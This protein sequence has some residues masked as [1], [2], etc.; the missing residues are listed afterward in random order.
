M[1]I[2][3]FCFLLCVTFIVT[4]CF[5]SAGT[6][7]SL[8]NYQYAIKKEDLQRAIMKVIKNNPN[9]YRDTSLDNSSAHASIDS[10]GAHYYN[11]IKNYVTI[12]IT[13]GQI[14]NEYTFR[15]Y[16]DDEYWKTSGSSEIFICY[17]FDKNHKGGSEGNGGVTKEMLKGFTDV[18]EKEFI[19]KIDRELNLTHTDETN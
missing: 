1:N 7:G 14:V 4:G 2:K 6:H 10:T 12:K 17:A 19:S 16:G 13:S 18:F 9:I 5:I 11:D 15:Y 8:K 3:S